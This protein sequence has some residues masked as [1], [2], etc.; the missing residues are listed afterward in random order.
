MN[1]L[2]SGSNDHGGLAGPASSGDSSLREKLLEHLFVGELMR[3]LWRRG[4]RRVELLRAEVDAGGY[5]VVLE[6]NGVLRHVQLKSSYRGA[7][8]NRVNINIGLQQK[9]CGCVVWMMF[10]PQTMELGPYVGNP[11]NSLIQD[12]LVAYSWPD[13]AEF[14]GIGDRK[15]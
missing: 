3:T 9:A 13:R 6:C 8:T 11:L 2:I 4:S 15:Y 7:K 1:A 5:D 14:V 10:D 12:N